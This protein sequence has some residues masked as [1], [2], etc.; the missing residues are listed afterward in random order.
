[1]LLARREVDILPI[2]GNLSGPHE[3]LTTCGFNRSLLPDSKAKQN[4]NCSFL[5]DFLSRSRIYVAL[6]QKYLISF[7]GKRLI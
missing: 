4:M 7:H 1:M 3:V 2:I 6:N 5:F